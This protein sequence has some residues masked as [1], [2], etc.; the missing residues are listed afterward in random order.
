MC[1]APK[2]GGQWHAKVELVV[3]DFDGVM[4]DNRV[5]V[6]ETGRESVS[7]NRADGLAVAY[8]K[9]RSIPQI[10]LSTEANNVVAKRARTLGIPCIHGCEN[11]KQ[12]LEAYLQEV[13]SLAANTVFIGNDINDLEAMMLCGLK[14]APADAHPRVKAIADLVLSCRGGEGVVREFC[15]RFLAM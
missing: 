15:E 3:Y 7:V 11:K 6:D 10:I 14:L 8:L 1:R 9:R 5:Y 4:T 13:R 2:D 12:A